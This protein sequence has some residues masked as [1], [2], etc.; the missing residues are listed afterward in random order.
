MN[1]RRSV[2]S[3]SISLLAMLLLMPGAEAQQK[4]KGK[5]KKKAEANPEGPVEAGQQAKW[6]GT[7]GGAAAGTAG[8]QTDYPAIATAKDGALCVTV[9]IDNLGK[10]MAGTAVQNMN[11]LFGLPETTGLRRAGAGL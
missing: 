10:G 2:F 6:A 4:K 3:I 11:L 1:R 7:L 5:G 9:A 8:K